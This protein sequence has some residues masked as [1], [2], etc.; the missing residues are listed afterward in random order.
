MADRI[1]LRLGPNGALGADALQW[2]VYVPRR[3]EPIPLDA[4]LNGRDWRPA[5]YVGCGK[6]V[7]MCC[8]REKGITLMD[9]A[10]L[11]LEG[12]PS[13]FD[14]WKAA[15]RP[16]E[17]VGKRTRRRRVRRRS[18]G[19]RRVQQAKPTARRYAHVTCSVKIELHS[20][21]GLK[22]IACLFVSGAKA[23]Q[24]IFIEIRDDGRDHAVAGQL[25]A[26]GHRGGQRVSVGQ[27]HEPR[28]FPRRRLAGLH[29]AVAVDQQEFLDRTAAAGRP[30]RLGEAVEANFRA[31][32]PAPHAAAN[33]ANGADAGRARSIDLGDVE[34]FHQ[35]DQSARFGVGVAGRAEIEEVEQ[36]RVSARRR[37]QAPPAPSAAQLRRQAGDRRFQLV[38]VEWHRGAVLR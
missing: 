25:V 12:Y 29:R 23:G 31:L 24:Q 36:R 11:E 34:G 32:L 5:A 1:F 21:R 19:P 17:T 15:P 35:L 22:S 30:Q 20:P 2:N 3:D 27:A 14:E 4:A 9:T 26:V 10:R 37:R 33:T 7:L 8:I 28:A 13:T 16:P 38:A 18:T 6:G